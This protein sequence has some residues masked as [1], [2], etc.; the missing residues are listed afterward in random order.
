[1]SIPKLHG[2][3]IA[4][5]HEVTA[6]AAASALEAGG[7]AFDAIVAGICA[8]C[9]AEPVLCSLAGGGYLLARRGQD[10]PVVYDFFVDT[11]LERRSADTLD[12]HPVEADFG[13][14]TQEFHIGLGSV[15]TPGVA[16]GLFEIHRELCRLPFRELVRPAVVAA[17][18]GVV[19]NR[20]QAYIFEVC[21]PIYVATAGS[22]AIYRST[23]DHGLPRAGELLRQPELADTFETLA[24]EGPGLIY[25]GEL[26]RRLAAACAAEGGQL[27]LEDL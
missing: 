20:L 8:A 19:V 9:V 16:A 6:D 18:E 26:G 1:M 2:A 25:G 23:G 10:E 15:A 14:A 12:L 11:P 7:N 13:D 17:R 5:G 24:R 4:C 21:G 3:A 27:T 22:R